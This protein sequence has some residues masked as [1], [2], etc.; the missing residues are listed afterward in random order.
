ME[1]AAIQLA[2]DVLA[3][4]YK[5]DYE[6]APESLKKHHVY[7]LAEKAKKQLKA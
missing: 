2:L 7:K 6:Q 5:K 1:S 3:D 4:A